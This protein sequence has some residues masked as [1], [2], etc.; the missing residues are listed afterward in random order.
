MKVTFY[1]METK[2]SKKTIEIDDE[3]AFDIDKVRNKAVLQAHLHGWDDVIKGEHRE[4]STEYH[5]EQEIL[6]K[7]PLYY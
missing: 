4:W 2:I 6:S 3:D 5:E 7:N 1:S